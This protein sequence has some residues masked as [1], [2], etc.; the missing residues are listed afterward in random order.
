LETAHDSQRW[1]HAIRQRANTLLD[2]VRVLNPETLEEVP[3]DG[4]SQGEVMMRG[5]IVMKGYLNNENATLD[6]FKSGYFQTG[7][8]GVNHGN[9]NLKFNILL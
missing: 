1:Q 8:L 3:P 6:A 9:G 4:I 7:D 2:E 5:N